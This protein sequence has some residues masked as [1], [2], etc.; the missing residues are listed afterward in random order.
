MPN[1]I[2]KFLRRCNGYSCA[3]RELVSSDTLGAK[4]SLS[5]RSEHRADIAYEIITSAMAEGFIDRDAAPA[6]SA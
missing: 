1:S 6:A 5:R 4:S 3:P 2:R